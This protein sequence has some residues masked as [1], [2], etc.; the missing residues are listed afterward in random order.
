MSAGRLDWAAAHLSLMGDDVE[1]LRVILARAWND[2]WTER[3]VT[4]PAH[5]AERDRRNPYEPTAEKEV[6]PIDPD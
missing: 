6:G 4:G 5:Y 3:V 2:G 1:T